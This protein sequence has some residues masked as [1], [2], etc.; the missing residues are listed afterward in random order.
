M[1]KEYNVGDVVMVQD[2]SE[3]PYDLAKITKRYSIHPGSPKTSYEGVL[4]NYGY[5]T[6]EF[7]VSQIIHD[8]DEFQAHEAVAKMTRA[9][10][11]D[12]AKQIVSQDRNLDYGSPEK[13]CADIAILWSTYLGV[14]IK[15][16]DVGAMMILLK[17]SRIKTSPSKED[18]WIDVAGYAAVGGEAYVTD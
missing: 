14:E 12:E 3:R 1:I 9:S 6:A 13:N 8:H 16:H 2:C 4:I 7:H 5:S 17:I 11:L 10:I 15:P 18:H